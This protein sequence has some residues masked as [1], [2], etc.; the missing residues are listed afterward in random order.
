MR[1]LAKVE[2]SSGAME[3]VERQKP[4]PGA[5]EVLV[6]VD[7]A[8]LCGSDAGIYEFESAF[9]RMELPTVIGH[10]Y[11]GRVVE[12]GDGVTEFGVGDRVVER[13]IRGC[14][15]CYQCRIGEEN[16]CQDA[17]ITGVDHDGAYERFIAVPERALHPIPDDVEQRHAAVAEPTS[18]A[19]RAVIENSRV[20]AGDRV[21]VEGPGP[22]GLLT[23][24]VAAAQGG[25]VV[26]SGV[27]QDADYRLPLAEELGFETVNV[28][29]DDTEARRER[30]TD[31][32]GYDVVF[33]TT[34]HPSG[35]TTAV[36]E[37]RKGGQIVLVG[38]TGE[39]SMPYSPLVRAEIDLQCSYASMYE[40]F[41]RSFR[42]I[43]DG[44]VDCETFVD[45][46]FSLLEADE[47]F[48]TFIEGGTCKPVFDISELA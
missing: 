5:G 4:E 34:G 6:E 28:A 22:I 2:R 9:E 15:E 32:V 24:Q 8:G 11:A 1:G 23:A 18:I 42:L 41:E 38:Q 35:L 12:V 30:H 26:V 20:G 36:E 17:V 19:A 16:V 44:D 7:Y 48:E 31:G 10:E 45:T 39:T 33:D 46:R 47:A 3:F 25:T 29:D 21:L 13:P 40:D 43:R 14:G 37:V 27:G